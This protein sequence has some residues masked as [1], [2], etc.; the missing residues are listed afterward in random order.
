[1]RALDHV[2]DRDRD[3]DRL[4]EDPGV[5]GRSERNTEGVA[6]SEAPETK[7]DRARRRIADRGDDSSSP[8]GEPSEISPYRPG[9][10]AAPRLP[11]P[12]PP[13]G[14]A[15]AGT[16]RP[17]AGAPG[18]GCQGGGRHPAGSTAGAGPP[19][20]S[21][22]GAAGAPC[23]NIGGAAGAAGTDSP[24]GGK[25][26]TSRD[27]GRDAGR[28]ASDED[29]PSAGGPGTGTGRRVATKNAVV[30][31]RRLSMKCRTAR[32]SSRRRSP[33]ALSRKFSTQ[34]AATQ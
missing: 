8:S 12:S 27:A 10:A 13:T 1:M 22:G 11:A 30:A 18:P 19:C 17:D 4:G 31:T 29:M 5:G 21:S 33:V 16:P 25:G 15:A 3:R 24:G 28:P 20:H 6:T 34:A 2:L 32:L 7:A 14:G 26:P 23:H 9:A